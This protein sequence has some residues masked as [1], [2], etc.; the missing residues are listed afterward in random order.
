MQNPALVDGVDYKINLMI[1]KFH[2][3]EALDARQPDEVLNVPGNVLTNKGIN[4][5]WKLVAGADPVWDVDGRYERAFTHE[6]SFIG[7]GN[8]DGQDTPS[9]Q[10]PY[11]DDE[12]LLAERD[13]SPANAEV[14]QACHYCYM[15]MN[16]AYPLAGDNQKIV[17]QS[18]YLPGVACFNWYEW[19]IA[20]GNGNRTQVEMEADPFIVRN[21]SLG[22][23]INDIEDVAPEPLPTPGLSY[24]PALDSERDKKTLLNHRFESMGRKY[25]SATWIITVEVSL[26]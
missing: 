7:I 21:G 4:L 9:A 23:P 17:F 2:T 1:E 11:A 8:A 12:K 24:D 25:A 22:P 15:K 14:R 5:I 19:C 10:T 26:S 18:T 13:Y 16:D 6:H 20:N 3:Q